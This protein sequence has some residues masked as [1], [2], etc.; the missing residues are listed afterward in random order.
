MDIGMGRGGR[1]M[2]PVQP[3]NRMMGGTVTPQTRYGPQM[4]LGMMGGMG[5]MRGGSR[6]P[7]VEIAQLMGSMGGNPAFKNGM[8]PQTDALGR[9]QQGGGF[10]VG[11]PSVQAGPGGVHGA[12]RTP[13][14]ELFLAGQANNALARR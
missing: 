8:T 6:D 14:N 9:A 3:G 4:G 11:P 7:R 1:P 2:G 13:A 10:P 12:L 5:G